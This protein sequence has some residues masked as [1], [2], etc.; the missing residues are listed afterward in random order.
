MAKGRKNKGT[1]RATHTGERDPET[2]ARLAAAARAEGNLVLAL[3]LHNRALARRPRDAGHLNGLGITHGAL[4]RLE[5]AVA[6][7]ERAVAADPTLMPAWF[8]LGSAHERRGELQAARDAYAAARAAAPDNEAAA[9]NLG[10][11]LMRLDEPEAAV[12]AFMAAIAARP[13]FGAAWGNLGAA[14]RLLGQLAEAEEA[15]RRALA[16]EPRQVSAWVNLGL[17]L[18]ARGAATEALAA[19]ESALALDPAHRTARHMRAALRGETLEPD[20]GYVAALFDDYASRYDHSLSV[21][22]GYRVPEALVALLDAA[23]IGRLDAGLDL[24]CGTGLLGE[25]LRPR[26][27]QLVGV[28]LSPAMVARARERAIYDRLVVASLEDYLGGDDVAGA[29]FDLVCAA[30]VL[31]YCGA[32]DALVG[33]V[34]RASKMGGLW[35]FSVEAHAG[36]GDYQ[37]RPSGRYAHARGYLQRLLEGAGMTPLAIEEASLRLSGGEPVEGELHLWRRGGS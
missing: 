12:E 25:R 24:G 33:G 2:L 26:L 29:P 16:L 3:Q 36:P 18:K 27:R 9:Y 15:L 5:E 37:L 4:G 8:N 20:R 22:L 7:F 21:D 1:K 35:L 28:D 13:D 10:G 17:V 34:A 6:S 11:V 14:R 19:F 23:G 30:D 32:L 31:V